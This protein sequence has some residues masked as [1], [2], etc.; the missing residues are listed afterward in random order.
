MV[1]GMRHDGIEV[2]MVWPKEAGEAEALIVLG[3]AL[4]ESAPA[5]VDAPEVGQTGGGTTEASPVEVATVQTSKPELLASSA[6]GGSTPEGALVTEGLSSAPI[7][8]TPMVATADSSVEAGS[9]QSLVRPSDEPL[10]WGG[11]L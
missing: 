2:H 11:R 5:P 9:S 7:G 6:I 8:P 10:A 4:M 1:P 3:E